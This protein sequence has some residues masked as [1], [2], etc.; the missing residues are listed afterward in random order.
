MA[1]REGGEGG[2]RGPHGGLDIARGGGF[3][4]ATIF[5]PRR[6]RGPPAEGRQAPPAAHVAQEGR[7]P[8]SRGRRASTVGK[9]RGAGDDVGGKPWR[10][11]TSAGDS[12][13]PHAAMGKDFSPPPCDGG[14]LNAGEGRGVRSGWRWRRATKWRRGR[15]RQTPTGGHPNL[16]LVSLKSSVIFASKRTNS[17]TLS[18][19]A[20]RHIRRRTR[21]QRGGSGRGCEVCAGLTNKSF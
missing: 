10:G 1:R 19:G 9:E 17:R 15:T 16:N 12:A 20:R 5:P 11:L 7:D 4:Q 6:R 3:A 14:G 13:Q 18:G 2:R 8:T 21:S